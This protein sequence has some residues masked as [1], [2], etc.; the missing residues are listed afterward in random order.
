MLFRSSDILLK[1]RI[2]TVRAMCTP[3]TRLLDVCCASGEHLLH[4]AGAVDTG[5]G[6]DFSQQ[7]L[8]AARR[9]ALERAVPNAA[10]IHANAR[11]LPL[12]DGCMDIAYSFSSLYYIPEVIQVFREVWR[13]LAPGG[14][15]VAEL[16]N[17]WSLNTIVCRAYPE[18]AHPCHIPVAQMVRDIGQAGFRIERQDRK[19]TR[20][21]S[22]H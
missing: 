3:S 5:V 1:L 10:F 17:L 13:V 18:L 12:A 11:A 8:D 22:S 21:N 19:S 2:D 20:L 7:F 15:F 4:L 16:G 14:C 6:V 9:R